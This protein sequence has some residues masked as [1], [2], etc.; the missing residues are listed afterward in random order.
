MP[1]QASPFYIANKDCQVRTVQ[2]TAAVEAGYAVGYNGGL[3]IAGQSLQGIARQSGVAG[4]YIACTTSNTASAIVGAAV[5]NGA[6]LAVG[7]GGKLVPAVAGNYIVARAL[8]DS[9]ANL[10]IT[11]EI[12]PEAIK[13]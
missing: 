12:K 5:A 4:D 10:F 1:G 13:A 2:L 6:D 3:A 11:V 9:S 7:A 8:S